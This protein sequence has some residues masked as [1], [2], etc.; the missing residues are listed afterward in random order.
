MTIFMYCNRWKGKLKLLP[1]KQKLKQKLNRW[2]RKQ[3]L[4]KS[5]ERLLL[6]TWFWQPC[7]RYVTC[8]ISIRW[9][10]IVVWTRERLLIVLTDHPVE[11]DI[12]MTLIDISTT[13]AEVILRAKALGFFDGLYPSSQNVSFKTYCLVLSLNCCKRGCLSGWDS[14]NDCGFLDCSWSGS[15]SL[16]V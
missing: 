4:G 6:L 3:M 14:S 5:I 7:Q 1:L 15:T 16:T 9:C 13:W 12:N 8:N 11:S 10:Q 2:P